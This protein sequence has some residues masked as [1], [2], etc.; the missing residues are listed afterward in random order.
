M[1]PAAVLA[2]L[3]VTGRWWAPWLLGLLDVQGNRIQSLADLAQLVLWVCALLALIVNFLRPKKSAANQN[4][5]AQPAQ[6]S[7]HVEAKTRAAAVGGDVTDSNVITG[8]NNAVGQDKAVNQPRQFRDLVMQQTVVQQS[9]AAALAPLHQLPPPPS[10]FTGR[11]RELNELLNRLGQGVTISGMH[12]LGGVSKTALALK[13][14]ERIKDRYPDA[15][16][17]LDLQGAGNDPLTPA[18]AMEHVIRAYHPMARLPE[19]LSELSAIYHST[20]H[21]QRALLLMDNARDRQQVEPQR[22][23]QAPRKEISRCITGRWWTTVTRYTRQ[24]TNPCCAGWRSSIRSGATFR[25]G[26]RGRG[27]TAKGRSASFR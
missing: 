24:E 10:D 1:A 21:N 27:D 23:R 18:R 9:E 14:A 7:T 22:K 2:A 11:E 13:L 5:L 25:P 19:S 3:A 12:G 17:Y 16:I 6:S 8:D 20:L 15:Q 26:R 4:Q